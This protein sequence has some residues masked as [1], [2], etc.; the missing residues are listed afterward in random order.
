VDGKKEPGKFINW[1]KQSALLLPETGVC[2]KRVFSQSFQ[3]HSGTGF[4]MYHS[5]TRTMANV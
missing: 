3:Q 5:K 4:Y 1:K 2:L